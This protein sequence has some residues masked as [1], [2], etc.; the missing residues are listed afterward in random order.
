[1]IKSLVMALAAATLGTTAAASNCAPRDVVLDR[2]ADRYGES[3][4]GAHLHDRQRPGVRDPGRSPARPRHR[5]LTA[6]VSASQIS[7]L[8]VTVNST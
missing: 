1:M 6:Q 8:P 5:R 2:L 4:R 3:R 7:L